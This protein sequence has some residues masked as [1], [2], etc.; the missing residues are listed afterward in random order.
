MVI[1]RSILFAMGRVLARVRNYWVAAIR[2][3]QSLGGK[4]AAAALALLVLCC[5]FGLGAMRSA[6][7]T[8][9]LAATSTPSPIP[10]STLLPVAA[11]P[12]TALPQLSLGVSRVKAEQTYS[13][14]GFAFQDAPL[15]DGRQRRMATASNKLSNVELIGTA[16]ELKEISVMVAPTK[17]TNRNTSSILYMLTALDL[18]VPEWANRTSWLTENIKAL[19]QDMQKG[20]LSAQRTTIVIKRAI[21][22]SFVDMGGA[23]LLFLHIEASELPP[24]PRAEEA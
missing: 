18:A 5:S 12:P 23:K 20:E 6:G 8:V 17:D 15:S 2:T 10:T 1:V 3:R 13:D 11:P 19:A 22:L 7:Q 4:A 21:K 9:G 16:A 14:L 24:S